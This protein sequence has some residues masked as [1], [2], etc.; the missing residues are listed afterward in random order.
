M[1]TTPPPVRSRRPRRLGIE[2]H[3]EF[4][5]TL[6]S[7]LD[8]AVASLRV[9]ARELAE[10]PAQ[11]EVELLE[12]SNLD[13][14]AGDVLR[15]VRL[16]EAIDGPAEPRRRRPMSL[17]DTLAQAAE[18]LGLDLAVRGAAGRGQFMGD[19]ESV[20][21]GAELVLLALA[22]D[23]RR[24]QVGIANDRL[25]MLEGAFDPADERKAWQ[26]RCGR[27]VL[28]GENCWVRL[29]SGRDGYRLEI[30]ALEP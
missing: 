15:L 1:T 30:R 20:R 11:S 3:T 8:T 13:R 5:G 16:L 26:L 17:S 9:A 27:R 4:V 7:E 22:G 10:Q 29:I 12:L 2:A 28:E 23:D 21:L 25:V 18:G 6:V 24:L 19:A 14:S